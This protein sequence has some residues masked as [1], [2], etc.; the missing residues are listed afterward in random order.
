[1][2]EICN[3]SW[4]KILLNIEKCE[5]IPD[6]VNGGRCVTAARVGFWLLM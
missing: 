3:F 1:M 5:K 6:S 4:Y 2:E